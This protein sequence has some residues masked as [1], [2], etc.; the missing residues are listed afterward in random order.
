MPTYR[1]LT[2]DER[3]PDIQ[4]DNAY[5]ALKNYT[6][7]QH[8]S[9][10]TPYLFTLL[11]VICRPRQN[12]P[13]HQ[14]NGGGLWKPVPIEKLMAEYLADEWIEKATTERKTDDEIRKEYEIPN[15]VTPGDFKNYLATNLPE[16]HEP[17]KLYNKFC[18]HINNSSPAVSAEQL[19]HSLNATAEVKSTEV[20]SV[21]DMSWLKNLPRP[22][23]YKRK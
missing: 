23:Y 5:E 11:K 15:S 9:R 19:Q 16:R 4:G 14:Q 1:F 6:D 2:P 8:N 7:P 13:I 20:I 22:K 10:Q 21:L 3:I 18:D 12:S 17:E